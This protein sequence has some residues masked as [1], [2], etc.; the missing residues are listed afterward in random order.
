LAPVYI[1]PL[2]HGEYL[3]NRVFGALLVVGLSAQS[4]LAFDLTVNNKSKYDIHELYVSKSKSSEW[5]PDQLRKDTIDAGKK[6]TL[7][8][9]S[10]GT[11][12]LKVV[13]EDG[14]ECTIE[15]ATFDESKEWTI[16][17]KMLER[18]D[19]FGN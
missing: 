15:D 13:D 11:W 6:F 4:A 3:M 12:D 17:S 14:T 1:A 19:K 16:T 18:C 10:D 9:V 7:R 2:L 8:N 5:G